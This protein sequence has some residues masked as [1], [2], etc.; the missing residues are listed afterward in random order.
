VEIC[1]NLWLGKERPQTSTERYKPQ[2]STERHRK[3]QV[4]IKK[5]VTFCDILWLGKERPQK[6]TERHRKAQVAIIK[7]VPFCGWQAGK[8]SM[9][10]CG[11]S[12]IRIP[13]LTA[14]ECKNIIWAERRG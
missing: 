3:A 4:A 6:S 9:K 11:Q 12:E 14:A 2:K 13:Q 1:A 5:S 8:K 10:I 7:S